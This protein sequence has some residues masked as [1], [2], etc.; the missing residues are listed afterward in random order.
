MTHCRPS[1]RDIN[2]VVTIGFSNYT[3]ADCKENARERE[4]LFTSRAR[5]YDD[6]SVNPARFEPRLWRRLVPITYTTFMTEQ[7]FSR[8]VSF[9]RGRSVQV[10]TRAL[11]S[12]FIIIFNRTFWF[13]EFKFSLR[14]GFSWFLRIFCSKSGTKI[15]FI[16][17]W[18]KLRKNFY[19]GHNISMF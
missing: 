7:C 15:I 13:L 11:I 4:R 6:T 9:R 3:V 17:I 1:R 5:C 10:L 12:S 2:V 18:G 8:G 19:L 14:W 16:S